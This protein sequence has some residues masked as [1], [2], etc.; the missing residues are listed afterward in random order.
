[1]SLERFLGT[2]R[3]LLVEPSLQVDSIIPFD[4]AVKLVLFRDAYSILERETILHSPSIEIKMPLVIANKKSHYKDKTRKE[5]NYTNDSIVSKKVI[6]LRDDY[7]CAYCGEYGDTIDHIWPR[8]LGGKSTW[9]NMVTCCKSC[10][11][12]KGSKTLEQMNYK[13]PI[14]PTGISY[15]N[16]TKRITPLQEALFDALGMAA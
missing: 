16:R 7:T 10:N 1:M 5:T 9:G 4:K 12:K 13:I 14:I 2:N 8:K 3:V 6:R 11:S 15:Q